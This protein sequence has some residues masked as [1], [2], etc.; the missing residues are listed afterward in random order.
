MV[1]KEVDS[2]DIIDGLEIMGE[3]SVGSHHAVFHDI[4]ELQKVQD[5]LQKL[6]DY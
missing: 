1:I 2:E 3:L 4:P 6:L 5:I